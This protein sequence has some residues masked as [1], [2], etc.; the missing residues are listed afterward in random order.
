MREMGAPPATPQRWLITHADGRRWEGFGQ[1]AHEAWSNSSCPEAFGS[2]SI[3]CFGQLELDANGDPFPSV[4]DGVDLRQAD[5]RILRASDPDDSDELLSYYSLMNADERSVLMSCAKK[6]VGK[7]RAE[8]GT[9]NLAT[10]T[11]DLTAEAADELLDAVV[12]CAMALRK[13]GWQ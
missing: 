11:R 12:Y 2:V 5:G 9:M 4:V 10:D 13:A 3:G 7:G 1:T 6:I 8:Y